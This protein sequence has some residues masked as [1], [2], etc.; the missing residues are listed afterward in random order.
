MTTRATQPPGSLLVRNAQVLTLDDAGREWARADVV[1]EDGRIAAL[2][3]RRR[4]GLASPC[5]IA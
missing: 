5:S 3:P 1:I 2:G 4:Q